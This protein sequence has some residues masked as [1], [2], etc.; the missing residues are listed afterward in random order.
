MKRVALVLA[1]VLAMAV[2]AW[3]RTWDFDASADPLKPGAMLDLSY[4]NE[5]AAGEKGFIRRS[6]DGESFVD[7]KGDP[8]RFWAVIGRIDTGAGETFTD[9]QLE[10]H[11]AFLAKR[12]VNMKRLFA[13]MYVNQEGAKLENVNEKQIEVLFRNI[14][15][16]R[17]HGIYVM[18]CP[19]WAYTDVPKSWGLGIEGQPWGGIFI[20]ERMQKAY[21]GWAR[22]FYTRVNPQTGLAIKDDPAVAIIQ[23]QNEDSLF[24][25]TFQSLKG[26]WKL[27]LQKRFADWAKTK[28]G[29]LDKAHQAWQG[30]KVEGDD[31]AAGLL[32]LCPNWEF[33]NAQTGGKGRRLTDQVTFMAQLQRDFYAEM[34]TY[35]RNDLGCKQLLNATNWRTSSPPTLDDLERWTYS[36]GD[37]MALNRYTGGV[38]K[39]PNNGWRIDPGDQLQ[40]QSVL[41]NP[42]DLPAAIK[43]VAGFP[44]MLTEVAWVSP[45]RYQA[46]GPFL[47][48][49][50][51]SLNGLDFACWFD[52]SSE[53]WSNV[54]LA[55]FVQVKGQHPMFKWNGL[56]PQQVGQFPAYAIAYRKGYIQPAETVV[57]ECRR[58]ED[59]AARKIP[60][61]AEKSGF[62]PVRDSGDFAAESSVKQELD[63]L[64]LLCGQVKVKFDAPPS[65]TRVVDVSKWL[66]RKESRVSSST[67]QL[68]WDYGKGVCTINAPAI[69]GVCGF[70]NAGGGKFTLSDVEIE[71]TADYATIAVVSLDGRPLSES[72]RMLVQV[73]SVVRPTGWEEKPATFDVDGKSVQGMEIVTVGKSPWQIMSVAG[74]L[75]IR[76]SILRRGTVLDVNGYARREL[77]LKTENS[78]VRLELPQDAMYVVLDEGSERK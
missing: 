65:Q 47:M 21:R 71:S 28:Y 55:T 24:F 45:E 30:A 64:I 53:Q 6:A 39:G 56:V 51:Q 77:P 62:D 44:F 3:A 16:A 52:A 15:I 42:T 68:Q 48:A 25:W 58:F 76:N 75:S 8:I 46:E 4:L 11:Y 57:E 60:V 26:P 10:R 70:L 29:S 72:R 59:M 63:P 49:A 32:G 18:V 67:G 7:G 23:I 20:D 37:V 9:E 22:E 61:V 38:H 36:V 19:F 17:K 35:L 74:N 1:A 69:Q 33:N 54:P 43:Q 5:K 31:A 34:V 27:A 73:G 50:Y 13:Q 12:G 14:A 66:S 41:K 78:T 40:D 2:I